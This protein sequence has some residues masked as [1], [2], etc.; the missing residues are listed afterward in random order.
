M[1]IGSL[2]FGAHSVLVLDSILF[3]SSTAGGVYRSCDGG[4]TWSDVS[5]GSITS[6][7]YTIVAMDS[8]LFAGTQGRGIF[9]SEDKGLNW[10]STSVGLQD[11]LV[12]TLFAFDN[13]LFAGT[14]RGGVFRS[15]DRGNNWVQ[16]NTGLPTGYDIKVVSFA[17]RQDSLGG[18]V[19]YAGTFS[20]G[21]YCSTDLGNHWTSITG[22]IPYPGG[23]T[24][25]TICPIDS[26]LAVGT[27]LHGMF[28][29]SNNGVTW[30]RPETEFT[31]PGGFNAIVALTPT[32]GS[33]MLVAGSS[34][35]PWVYTSSDN[36]RTWTSADSGSLSVAAS[37][38][39]VSNGFLYQGSLNGVWRRPLSEVITSVWKDERRGL[40]IATALEQNYPNP[41]NPATTIQ[42]ALPRRSH[43]TLAVYNTLGQ[44]LATLVNGIVEAGYHEVQFNASGLA[45]G[46]YFY[47][48][49]AGDFVR[50]RKFCLIK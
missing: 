24:F 23:V 25:T 37:S 38:F 33:H 35:Q 50:V 34:N 5:I 3:F 26:F 1:T 17:A 40:P 2:N 31:T 10:T 11:S 30:I 7:I 6:D 29:S 47:R 28:R 46:V 45:S 8:T 12:E 27:G 16:I 4:Q 19:L 18:S 49:Q 44:Q 15:S 14:N 36:G 43:V 13:Y 42:Y 9:R 20:W 39:C 32:S 41:F 22:D 48:L 21:I